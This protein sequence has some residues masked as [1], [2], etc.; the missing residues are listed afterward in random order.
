MRHGGSEGLYPGSDQTIPATG[1][2]AKRWFVAVAE[3]AGD[4]I[5]NMR[6]YYDN[7]PFLAQFG[8]M[9]QPGSV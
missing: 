5:S 9:E 4:K 8:L 6:I 7:L 2:Q 1:K 3:R